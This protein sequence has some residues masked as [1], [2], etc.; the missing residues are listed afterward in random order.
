MLKRNLPSINVDI[1][2]RVRIDE[3]SQA[4]R[5]RFSDVQ[6][7]WYFWPDG[8]PGG[9]TRA[10]LKALRYT[11]EPDFGNPRKLFEREHEIWA[12]LDHPN[13]LPFLGTATL[14]QAPFVRVYF[15]SPWM[16]NGNVMEY[17]KNNPDVARESLL[18]GIAAGMQYLHHRTPS[19]IHGDIKGKNILV[20][21]MG[22]PLLCDFGL[23]A[24]EELE[25]GT[26]TLA[27]HGTVCF[28]A[29]ERLAPGKFGLTTSQ[30]RTCA[31]DI[32]SFGLTA[33]EI[34]SGSIPFGEGRHSYD[35]LF[36]IVGGERPPIP[37]NWRHDVVGLIEACWKQERAERPTAA[38]IVEYLGQI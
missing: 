7:G 4:I 12:A 21:E 18:P 16:E 22:T 37:S 35:V 11:T 36:A 26:T 13:I 15:V 29:P 5:T 6:R 33:Y 14:G 17:L 32:F 24:Y 8:T 19:V 23:S 34:L 3:T 38:Q 30:T 20:D 27:G 31:A 10:A 9:S 1:T 25:R 28:M 2:D